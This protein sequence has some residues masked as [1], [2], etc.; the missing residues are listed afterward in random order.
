[1]E[2]FEIN[3]V[4]YM[5]ELP[6]QLFNK[7]QPTAFHRSLPEYNCL[8]TVLSLTLEL[9]SSNVATIPIAATSAT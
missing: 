4:K 1:M 7:D 3:D 6:G 2:I 9:T 8:L 5:H